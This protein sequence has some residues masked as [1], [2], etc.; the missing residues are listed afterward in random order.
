M[1][2]ELENEYI[3]LICTIY[4]DL[5][6]TWGIPKCGYNDFTNWGIKQNINKLEQLLRKSKL[7]NANR[8]FRKSVELRIYELTSLY[9]YRYSAYYCYLIAIKP[10]LEVIESIDYYNVGMNEE[11]VISR[12]RGFSKVINKA[13]NEIRIKKLSKL[14]LLYTKYLIKKDLDFLKSEILKEYSIDSVQQ[15]YYS[16]ELFF[17]EIKTRL[18][19]DNEKNFFSS[20]G[21]ENLINYLNKM[22]NKKNSCYLIETLYKEAMYEIIM[23]AEFNI[24]DIKKS[25]IQCNERELTK[26]FQEI[27]TKCKS[28]FGEEVNLLD[29]LNF[30]DTKDDK[31][32]FGNFRYIKQPLTAVNMKS[33]LLYSSKN[34]I[35][36]KEQLKLKVV[37]EIYPGHHYMNKCFDRT[38]RGNI[39]EMSRLNPYIEE[40][41]AKFC[42]Y[43]YANE[44]ECSDK[45]KKAYKRNKL[46]MNIMFIIAIDIHYFKC[47]K[48][49]IYNK[50]VGK[51][52][53]TIEKINSMLLPINVDPSRALIYYMGYYYFYTYVNQRKKKDKISIICKDIVNN[54]MIAFD[55]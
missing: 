21:A 48:N 7:Q 35:M 47:K 14:D 6:V 27:Y 50:L 5:A 43:F 45:I 12:V 25:A 2:I 26:L 19:E 41:W 55:N 9:E 3:E 38:V 39:Y 31:S 51:C 32:I 49:D 34:N 24:F 33:F 40:G 18:T 4:P 11:V 36:S 20:W 8:N 1:S 17:N 10:L 28:I 54:P 16:I 42:E 52:G 29:S 46:L 37:H 13:I 23:N 15:I 53:M 22:T 30:I 44:I